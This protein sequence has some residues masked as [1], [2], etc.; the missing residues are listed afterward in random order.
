MSARIPGRSAAR[1]ADEVVSAAY[2]PMK[3]EILRAVAG[4]LRAEGM[5][6]LG[7]HDLEAAYNEAWHGVVQHIIGGR[8]VTSLSGLLFTICHR[9]ALDGLRRS[10]QRGRVDL[11]VAHQ[12]ARTDLVE[13][14]D[15]R[16]KLA[17]LF[18]GLKQRLSDRE[19]R[20]LTLCLLHGYPRREA[21]ELL[22]IDRRAFERIMD[23]ASRKLGTI[24]TSINARGCG[25]QEWVALMRDYALGTLPEGGRDH[26][27]AQAHVEGRG[28]CASCRRYVRGLQGLAGVLPPLTPPPHI[29]GP[30]AGLLGHLRRLTGEH[31]ATG[32]AASL[33]GGGAAGALASGGSGAAGMTA[34]GGALKAAAAIGAAVA[35]AVG[36]VSITHHHRAPRAHVAATR[37]APAATLTR[38]FPGAGEPIDARVGAHVRPESL[39]A[40]TAAPRIKDRAPAAPEFGFEGPSAGGPEAPTRAIVTA[41]VRPRVSP[42]PATQSASGEFGFE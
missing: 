34:T 2:E 18:G 12:P 10:D 15:D 1:E 14:L 3:A 37:P 32:S 30:L 35:L 40:G 8:P 31:G 23:D 27:R 38:D 9:R 39:T 24:I 22:G 7:E 29:A 11:D 36:G 16:A 26:R 17:R 20:A 4:R 6:E 33:P 41:K 5:T 13:H 19:R 21:A 25:D 42:P 28:A